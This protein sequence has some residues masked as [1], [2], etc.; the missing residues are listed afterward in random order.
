MHYKTY[1]D[2]PEILS[3]LRQDTRGR[4]TKHKKHNTTQKTKE[5]NNTFTKM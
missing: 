3:I 2:N 5:M 1:R 4:K